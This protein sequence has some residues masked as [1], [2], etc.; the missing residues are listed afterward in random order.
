MV[1]G[2]TLLEALAGTL[3]IGLCALFTV[4]ALYAVIKL[5]R[6]SRGHRRYGGETAFLVTSLVL[7]A[8]LV[9]ALWICHCMV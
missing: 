9:A 8:L 2:V 6:E 5:G 3:A 1:D 7:D 4:F